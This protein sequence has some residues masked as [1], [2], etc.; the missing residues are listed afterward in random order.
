[1]RNAAWVR[2]AVIATMTCVTPAAA[3]VSEWTQFRGPNGSGVQDGWNL[4]SE[5]GP[6]RHVMWKTPMPPGHSSPVLS[7]D[8]V[9]V[10]ALDGDALVTLS[11]ERDSGRIVWRR[12]VP[13][14]RR[15]HVDA[16]NHP[17]SPSPATDGLNVFV[18]FQDYGLIS[19]DRGGR[20]RW[21]VPLGP[22]NN[23]YGMGASPIVADGLVV[24]ACDHNAGS[25]LIALDKETGQLR[26]RTER[27]DATTGHST[28][29]VYRPPGDRP[30]ILLAGS[31][32]LTAY[33]LDSGAQL[34][35]VRGLSV[36]MKATPVLGDGTVYVHGTS[37]S[38]FQDS[39]GG[40]VPSFAQLA[41]A[42]D[43]DGDGRFSR[44]EVPDDLARRL[45]KLKDVNGDGY[46]DEAEWT[47]YQASRSTKGGMWAFN[48][49]GRGDVTDMNVRW[50][51]D[52]AVP[53]LPSPLLYRGTL[54]M[55]NDGGIATALDPA[56]GRVWAQGRI[57]GAIDR[58]FASPVAGDGKIFVVSESGKVAVLSAA[59]RLD[60][61]AVN[62]L[63]DLAYA[64]PAI[65]GGRLYIRTRSALYCFGLPTSSRF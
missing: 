57:R 17:A 43:Q 23:A 59:G 64:T 12:E 50:H 42:H 41:P 31:F 33:A 14:P 27:P 47:H 15:Q 28:P 6:D 40:K 37:T 8:R 34:W 19:Y 7:D 16:R 56:S 55:V 45:F 32:F 2:V 60:V 20:E 48:L 25:F 58:Y 30:Q 10:T 29:I 62:D 53:Q 4:P 11:L 1:M 26:W 51:Y 63:G 5:F 35:W 22:F 46:L 52:R 18:F 36:E 3:S 38:Q 61:I 65:A 9:F 39:Y 49:G 21:R 54:Y 24:L 44:D 13:R